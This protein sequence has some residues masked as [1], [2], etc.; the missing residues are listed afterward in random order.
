[1]TDQLAEI[2]N[3]LALVDKQASENGSGQLN[4]VSEDDLAIA[5]SQEN[6]DTLC[7]IAKWG[8]WYRW[9]S[10]VWV[11]DDTL[12]VYDA[13]RQHIR[14]AVDISDQKSRIT[15]LRAQTVAAVEKLIRSDRRHAAT[16]DQW[17]A[18]P[19]VIN[20][21]SGIVDLTTGTTKDHESQSYLTKLAGASLNGHCPLWLGFLDEVT[22]R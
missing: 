7:Y 15:V 2:N 13:I 19:W 1:M 3:V 22:P 8:K 17:D 18:D 4:Q 6:A 5:F 14:Q 20:S 9:D 16:V 11:E 21:P 12:A 10:R